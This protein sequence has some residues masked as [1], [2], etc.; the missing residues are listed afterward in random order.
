[1]TEDKEGIFKE[2]SSYFENNPNNFSIFE[3]E[4]DINVQKEYYKY[5]ENLASDIKVNSD[6]SIDADILFSKDTLEEDKKKILVLLSNINE[7]DAYRTIEKFVN[8][9][10]PTLRAWAVVAM[11]QSRMLLESS[12]LEEKSVFISTGLGGKGNKLRYFCVLFSKYQQIFK[13]NHK[14]ILKNEIDFAFKEVDA[15]LENIDYNDSVICF[16][17]LI[18]IKVNLKELFDNII[19]ES[20]NYGNFLNQNM[21]ITNVK[22]LSSEEIKSILKNNEEKKDNDINSNIEIDKK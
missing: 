20:N 4:I 13:N 11:Q 17:A 3:E 19:N 22:S 15:E 16:K 18:P 7:V 5:M 2:L 1:M 12:L 10:D 21:I 9:E 14:K 8:L 6:I